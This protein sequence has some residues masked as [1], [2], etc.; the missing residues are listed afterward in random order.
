ML[1]GRSGG[2]AVTPVVPSTTPPTTP[3]AGGPAKVSAPAG[4]RSVV[5]FSAPVR[6]VTPATTVATRS[7]VVPQP[8]VILPPAIRVAA[9]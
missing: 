3:P 8:P 6:F 7:V 4:A 5:V 1:R 2:P 9:R